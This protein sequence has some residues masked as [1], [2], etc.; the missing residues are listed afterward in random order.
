MYPGE[1][2]TITL[3]IINLGTSK[4]MIEIKIDAGNLSEYVSFNDY[5]ILNIPVNK[6]R[7]RNLNIRLSEN[8]QPGLYEIIITATSINSG[9]KVKASYILK[10]EIKLSDEKNEPEDTTPEDGVQQKKRGRFDN[11]LYLIIIIGIIILIIGLVL[12]LYKRKK[13]MAK[14]IVTT[15][16]VT[17]KPLPPQVISVSETL[18]KLSNQYSAP[19]AISPTIATHQPRVAP[20]QVPTII[21]LPTVQ[22]A[23]S[24]QQVTQVTQVA[25]VPRLPPVQT[26]Q[27]EFKAET[28]DFKPETNNSSVLKSQIKP[29]K[30]EQGEN[31][32]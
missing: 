5:S 14:E 28:S 15:E 9:E 13:R 10:L 2:D 17:T 18:Q 8:V 22:Q 26:E 6:Y 4:D 1:N 23:P 27:A 29:T 30:I 7:K 11:N 21:A 31:S 3:T 16:T 32:S 19:P 12:V 25:N 24:T 20:T